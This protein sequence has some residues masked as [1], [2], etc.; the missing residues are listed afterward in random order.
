MHAIVKNLFKLQLES[1]LVLILLAFIA[2][3]TPI[4]PESLA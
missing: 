1:S 4:S 2:F 3:G